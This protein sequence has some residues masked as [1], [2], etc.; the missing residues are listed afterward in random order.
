VGDLLLP[1][2]ST[3]VHSA[4]GWVY[5]LLLGGAIGAAGSILSGLLAY[6][7]CRALGRGAAVR[8]AGE[9]DLARGE[10]LFSSAGG[11]IVALSR[12]LPLLPEVV[13]CMA[14]LARMPLS[15]FFLALACGS[16]PMAYAFAAIGALGVGHPTLALALSAGVPLLLWPLA[17]AVVRRRAKTPT[18]DR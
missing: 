2:P 11:W 3:A 4:L 12:W 18:Q 13:A 7:L 15:P 16:V 8:L 9:R 1:V 17:R 5:G 14:G 6:S 10:E